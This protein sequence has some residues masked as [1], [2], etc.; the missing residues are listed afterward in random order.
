MKIFVTD[1]ADEQGNMPAVKELAVFAPNRTE[2]T[3]DLLGNA[4]KHADADGVM[5]MTTKEYLWWEA[6]I[7][8][9]EL[10]EAETLTAAELLKDDFGGD[11]EKAVAY[12]KDQIADQSNE[13]DDERGVAIRVISQMITNARQGK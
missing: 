7:R 13:M 2:W 1:M 8:G 11:A 5:R 6:Y 10:T 4:G 9:A 12:I 3:V